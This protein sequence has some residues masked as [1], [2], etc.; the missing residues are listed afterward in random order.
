MGDSS[1]CTACGAMLPLPDLAGLITCPSCGRVTRGE[2]PGSSA[3]AA[4]S[5]AWP[6]PPVPAPDPGSQWEPPAPVPGAPSAPPPSA[7]PSAPKAARTAS[8][9]GCGLVPIVVIGFVGFM[10]VGALRSCDDTSPTT[11]GPSFFDR[12]SNVITIS[13]SATVL[14]S[15]PDATEVAVIQQQT[16]SATVRRLAI[17]RFTPEGSEEV[18]T[19]E[20]LDE[21]ASRIEVA[22]VDDTL[23]A[24][25]EDVLLALD[26][27]TGETRWRTTLRDQ[28]TFN[29]PSCFVALGEQVV[30]R[31]TDAYVSAY[32]AG[33]A[34]PRWSKR[35]RSAQGSMSVA[36]D[37][38]L[39]VDDPEAQQ[40]LT[41]VQL[42][43]PADGRVLRTV[44]PTCPG[45]G[46]TPW[47]LEMRPGDQVHAVPGSDDVVALFGFGEGC[48]VRWAPDSG[49]PRWASRIEGVSSVSPEAVLVG[50]EDLVAPSSSTQ[51][52]AVALDDGAVRVLDHPVDTSVE[53]IQIVGR[54]LLGAS[55][56]SRG[57]PKRGLAAWDL[58]TGERTWGI[59]IPGDPE[60]VSYLDGF[61]SDALFDGSPR[62]LV[63]P[64]VDGAD[65]VTF[66]GEQRTFAVRALDLGDG[67]L[68]PEVRRGLLARYDSGTVSLTVEGIEADRLIVSVDNALQALPPGGRGPV[69]GYPS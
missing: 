46:S 25:Y 53:P 19:S 42:L 48:A 34:E 58:A 17:V 59:R 22:E 26:R 31:T 3:P 15:S 24:A 54:T 60:P 39:V 68:G 18:W 13:G 67:T 49:A 69:V 2:V 10:L 30:I 37:R 4:G 36:N 27:E 57:T 47:E 55:A 52:V 56:T 1:V 7:M 45:E 44:A 65:V 16:G 40:Q 38:L 33:S 29:C 14:R 64:T 21:S 6:P 12:S 63:Q 23:F 62:F 28:V 66:E 51:S 20:P 50:D 43:D 35:L 61:S 32:R 41:Q 11:G 9:I 5:A 8:K